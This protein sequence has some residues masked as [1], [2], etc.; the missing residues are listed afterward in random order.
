MTRRHWEADLGPDGVITSWRMDT[1]IPNAPPGNQQIHHTAAFT[2]QATS[3]TRGTAA[4]T[5]AF[6]WQKQYVETVPGTRSCTP[7]GNCC[8]TRRDASR[9]RP[10]PGSGST[11]SRAGTRA[12]WATRTSCDGPMAHSRSAARDSR[13]RASRTWTGTAAWR[14]TRGKGDLQAGSAAHHQRARYRRHRAPGSRPTK[15]RRQR[16]ITQS[17]RHRA[18]HARYCH[19]DHRLQPARAARRDTRRRPAAIRPGLADRRQRRR[20]NWR[21]RKR[22]NW[23]A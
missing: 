4:G 13:A 1:D 5:R 21:R 11:S 17:A 2:G 20:R 19:A 12:T 10:M 23:P 15:A 18:R 6:I 22:S 3:F 14:P 9:T 7:P 8:S 16:D